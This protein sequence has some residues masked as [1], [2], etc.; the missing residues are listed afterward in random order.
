M[1]T[2]EPQTYQDLADKLFEAIGDR[3]YL[4]GKVESGE[5]SLRTTIVIY[6]DRE[7]GAIRDIVPIWWEF[8]WAVNPDSSATD[9]S[10]SEFRKYILK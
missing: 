7:N 8:A 10:W 9:F 3:E 2:I 6:R 1:I 5:Y 4:N